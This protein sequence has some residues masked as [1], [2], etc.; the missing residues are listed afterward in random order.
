MRYRSVVF[1]EL[2]HGDARLAA[3]VQR[4]VECYQ[5][6]RVYLFGSRARGDE[7]A[8]SDYDLFV[9]VP[10]DADEARLDCDRF[11]RNQRGLPCGADVVVTTRSRFD[12][13]AQRVPSSLDAIVAREGRLLYAA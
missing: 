4:L 7:G 10:D 8:D 9:L 11:Y 6:E 13:R 5:P 2:T 1:S 12:A 3:L